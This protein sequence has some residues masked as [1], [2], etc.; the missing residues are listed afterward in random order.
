[1]AVIVCAEHGR[2]CAYGGNEPDR[3]PWCHSTW[4][5]LVAAVARDPDLGH[6]C[7]SPWVMRNHRERV[8]QAAAMRREAATNL[9]RGANRGAVGPSATAP[10]LG[11]QTARIAG[12]GF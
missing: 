12:R 4:A 10:E 8:E 5:H 1:M 7:E 6:S 2:L 9:H 11:P 3:C